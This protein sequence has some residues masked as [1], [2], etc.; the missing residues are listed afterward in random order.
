[1]HQI[2]DPRQPRAEPAA[3]MEGAEMFR[4]E[5]GDAPS[6]PAPARRPAPASSSSRWW[7]RCR[8]GRPRPRSGSSSTTSACPA[9]VLSA[10]RGDRHQRDAEAAG[11]GDRY[12]PVPRV[13][14]E[15]DSASTASP[16]A[17]IAEIAM[18]GLGRMDEMRRRAGR[19]EGGGDLARHMAGLAHARDDHPPLRREQHAA[20]I[21]EALGRR[22]GQR[23]PAPRPRGRCTLRPVA[24]T[25]SPVHQWAKM[26]NRSPASRSSWAR[27]GRK[28]KQASAISL[29]PSRASRASSCVLQPVQVE[30]VRRGIVELRLGQFSAPPVRRLLVL[31]DID[32]RAVRPAG[33][34][35]RAGRYRCA[36][37]SRRSWCTRPAPPARRRR[38]TS[39]RC[40]TGRNGTAS[41]PPDRSAAV[42]RF[43]ARS[44]PGRSAPD[45]HGR[46]RPT[47]AP[48][49]AG[50]AAGSGPWSRSRWRRPRR[51]A[52]LREGRPCR[53]D[54]PWRIRDWLRWRIVSRRR[55]WGQPPATGGRAAPQA[56]QTPRN[57][58]A[59]AEL[60]ARDAPGRRQSTSGACFLPC[61]NR[62]HLRNAG[63]SASLHNSRRNPPD[64]A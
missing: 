59:R 20:G 23:A 8:C 34:S 62:C 10:L 15:F 16:C 41:A 6:A 57:A 11:I 2:G 58:A 32:L 55:R 3:G 52:D 27:V 22:R 51:D 61:R 36:P 30:H 47:A 4:G 5:A 37:A 1:M 64:R 45:A 18:A 28:A 12:R 48:G 56:D 49:T 13:S 38:D 43:G 7:G 60:R 42:A 21:G 46:R 63:F 54:W 33:S 53:S 17:I 31:G 29:R 40:R 25:A 39:P 35:A 44:G 14:P 50:R 19:G 24:V 26:S 9:S